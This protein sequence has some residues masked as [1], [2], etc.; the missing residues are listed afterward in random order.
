MPWLR[1]ARNL[2][3][4]GMA[5]VRCDHRGRGGRAASWPGG[6]AA[7]YRGRSPPRMAA[8]RRPAA[9]AAQLEWLPPAD[10]GRGGRRSGEAT[11]FADGRQ[12][13][14][15]AAPAAGRVARAGRAGS[16]KIGRAVGVGPVGQQPSRRAAR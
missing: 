16:T 10:S 6:M 7:A 15:G 9:R 3:P 2:V 14:S 8:V 5:A 4:A 13:A 12:P 1:L 11:R